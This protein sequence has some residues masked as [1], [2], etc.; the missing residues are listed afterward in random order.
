MFYNITITK[1]FKGGLMKTNLT[2]K[3]LV[4]FLGI[5]LLLFLVIPLAAQSKESGVIQGKVIDEEGRPIPGVAV[6]IKGN[7]LI[8]GPQTTFTTKRGH[9]RFPALPVGVYQIEARLSGFAPAKIKGIRLHVGKTLTIDLKL[10]LSKMREEVTVVGK[11]PTVDVTDTT[12]AST[13]LTSEILKNIPNS[14]FTTQLVNLAPGV[15]DNVAFGGAQS[16]SVSYQIDGVDVSDPE[17]GTAWVFIDY[18]V[19]EEANVLT[20]GLNAEYGGFTGAILNTIT[21]SGGNN[22]NGHLEFLYQGSSWNNKNSSDPNLQSPKQGY[23]DLNGYLGGPVVRDRLWF[24]TGLQYYRTKRYPAGFPKAVD[25]K[26]PR[27][28]LKFTWQPGEKDRVQSFLEYDLYN[29]VNRGA[30]AYTDPEATVT[31]KSPEI[32]Y[33]IGW[34][35]TFNSDTYLDAKVAGYS[36]YYYLNPSQGYDIAGHYDL[37]TERYSVNSPY[38]FK[39]DRYRSQANIAL[40]HHSDEFIKG[41]HDFKFGAEYERSYT[42][43]RY[44]YTTGITYVDYNGEPYLA[45]GY[46]GYDVEGINNRY[47]AYAQDSWSVNDKLTV[48]YGVRYNLY[49]GYLPH[50]KKTV[51]KSHGIA[52]RIGFAYD[53]FG[54]HST[55]FKAHYGKYYEGFF[56]AYY[57]NLDPTRSDFILYS[58][59]P[60]GNLTEL[61]RWPYKNAYTI[62]NK[63][64]HPNMDQFVVSLEREIFK[65][66]SIG[67][68]FIWRNNKDI[69][70]RVNY[71]GV[72]NTT[73]VVDP[74]TGQTYTVYNEV[75]PGGDKYIITNPEKG[76]YPIVSFTPYRKYRGIEFMFN[77]R[78]SNKW[79]LMVSYVYSRTTGN[80]NNNFWGGTGSNVGQSRVF[81][82]PNYQI[83]AE[84]HL[85]YDPTH[86]LKISGTFILPF[87]ISFSPYFELVSGFTYTRLL[88]VRLNQGM[89]SFMTEPRGSRRLDTRKTLNLRF[90]KMFFLDRRRLGLILDVFNVFN[91]GTPTRVIAIAGPEFAQPTR[92]VMPRGFRAGVRFFF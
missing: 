84:G 85:T 36:G 29:G 24:F 4:G 71:T 40:S 5:G 1:K 88:R 83:N 13:I 64:R 45:Y 21:K 9:Y 79:Q 11:S 41:S 67:V 23:F 20:G 92:L 62:D 66:T 80:Y 8:G 87:D 60:N 63:I 74:Y 61:V 70:D 22:F 14:E 58:V 82:D 26:Q 54:D 81:M 44:G 53:V 37:Y 38:Y 51:Y 47:S 75:N 49:R 90:E 27:S 73:T 28:F 91:E 31:Q 89:V 52:P 30:D 33:S 43:N 48:N 86:M 35:H 16:S 57:Y 65:D 59:A 50:I 34:M 25:Y 18:N 69:I 6:I 32:S 77:K 39:A 55:A 7:K 19:I 68:T 17:G 46:E 42:R 78:F 76:K 12:S 15:V 56:S 72:F 2:K 10:K 3:L